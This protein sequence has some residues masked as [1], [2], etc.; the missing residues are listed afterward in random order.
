LPSVVFE[1]RMATS[2][3]QI[4]SDAVIGLP[5]IAHLDVACSNEVCKQSFREYLPRVR[6]RLAQAG[7]T[8]NQPV[9]VHDEEYVKKN[10][11]THMMHCSCGGTYRALVGHSRTDEVRERNMGELS[12]LSKIAHVNMIWVLASL[13]I[14]DLLPTAGAVMLRASPHAGT[15]NV[16][17]ADGR[18][19]VFPREV[20]ISCSGFKSCSRYLVEIMCHALGVNFQHNMHLAP[21]EAGPK[22]DLLIVF[23]NSE[24]AV[25]NSEKLT[26][27]WQSNIPV[28]NFFWLVESYLKWDLQP[29]DD[30]KYAAAS[31]DAHVNEGIKQLFAGQQDAE[32]QRLGGFGVSQEQETCDNQTEEE[33]DGPMDQMGG[34]LAIEEDECQK[35]QWSG[36]GDDSKDNTMNDDMGAMDDDPVGAST[37]MA[38]AVVRAEGP[39][40]ALTGAGADLAGDRK[41][42]SPKMVPGHAKEGSVSKKGR[43]AKASADGLAVSGGCER[44]GRAVKERAAKSRD[45]GDSTRIMISEEP[46]AHLTVS[47]MHSGDQKEVLP[48]MRSLGVPYSVGSH[49]WNDKF[50]HVI[51][52]SVR[53][54]Q[55]M[56]SAIACGRW[57][58]SPEFLRAS[59]NKS[60]L[61]LIGPSKLVSEK[62]YELREGNPHHDIDDNVTRFWRERIKG[63]G[64]RAFE[65]LGICIHPSITSRHAPSKED[66]K[67]IVK[68]GGAT[69]VPW[70]GISDVL[71]DAETVSGQG[72]DVVVSLETHVEQAKA[73]VDL[74]LDTRLAEA[75]RRR[76]RPSTKKKPVVFS[77]IEI[78]Q[79]LVSLKTKLE[80]QDGSKTLKA[81]LLMREIVG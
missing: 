68:A 52:P 21:S 41:R 75:G 66:I 8:W 50:T 62:K 81:R 26:R 46:L 28:V 51:A 69:I 76:H 14:R 45:A 18:L 5:T 2:T 30:R 57:I 17:L 13:T 59:V 15:E 55:K 49:S 60:K 4:F 77:S 54:N 16:N 61:A 65:G 79:W 22:T 72:V 6:G 27:A 38:E 36:S 29:L 47:G 80:A 11:L 42:K 39:A 3:P 44:S 58:V 71:I 32:T 70:S 10:R 7:C 48:L 34:L 35:P 19:G 74:R 9:Q 37:G 31:G 78:V 40:G 64:C 53:R 73:D 1:R 67:A 20:N 25:R 23:D 12:H 43:P 24:T 56:L 63:S 33:L